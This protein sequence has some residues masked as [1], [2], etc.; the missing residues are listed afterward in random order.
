VVIRQGLMW[1]LRAVLKSHEA[2]VVDRDDDHLQQPPCWESLL[3]G[4]WSSRARDETD[5]PWILRLWKKG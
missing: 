3:L 4:Y 5:H 1:W 2:E